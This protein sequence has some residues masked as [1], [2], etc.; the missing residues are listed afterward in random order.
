MPAL[1]ITWR[2]PRA[3]TRA[4]IV[5]IIYVLAF[6]LAPLADAVS[7]SLGGVLGAWLPPESARAD[8]SLAAT[9]A[10]SA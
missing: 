4:V 3:R 9:A 8:R 1:C 6:H 10:G 7:L 5:I 2:L